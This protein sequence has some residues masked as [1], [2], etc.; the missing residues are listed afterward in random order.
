HGGNVSGSKISECESTQDVEAI[1]GA[2]RAAYAL[3]AYFDFCNQR[4]I[5]ADVHLFYETYT[6]LDDTI[7]DLLDPLAPWEAPA[8]YTT[9]E[10]GPRGEDDGDL[11]TQDWWSDNVGTVVQYYDDFT[12][13][14]GTLLDWNVFVRT[15]WEDLPPL[16]TNG[17]LRLGDAVAV[18][19][20]S[21][22]LHACYNTHQ[23]GSGQSV[24][25]A[26]ANDMGALIAT[27]MEDSLVDDMGGPNWTTLLNDATEEDYLSAITDG[28]HVIPNFSVHDVNGCPCEDVCPTG[29][30]CG[31]P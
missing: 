6:Q 15:Q 12:G 11:L 18:I 17:G 9:L 2:N 1:N 4:G 14:R 24:A 31:T 27:R 28:G 8:L 22:F 21:G 23:V 26:A 7:D 3:D 30:A 16:D 29:T 13:N 10:W 5:H 25:T 19:S 20:T